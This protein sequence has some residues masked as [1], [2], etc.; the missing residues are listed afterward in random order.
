MRLILALTLGLV[1]G[2]TA[3]Q[4]SAGSLA[5]EADI[6]EGLFHVAVADKIRRECSGIVPR[7]V[8]VRAYVN[9][10][11]DK[12]VSRGF[13]RAEIEAHLDDRAEKVKMRERRNAYF[14]ANGA[15]SEDPESLC[16]LGRQEIAKQSPIGQLLKAK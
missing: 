2:G 12:A 10:L 16:R 1:L 8:T 3:A 5:D 13:D 4:A 9:S 15:S 14:E 6:Y 7:I 11:K